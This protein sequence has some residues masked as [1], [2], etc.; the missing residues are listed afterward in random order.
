[1]R[2]PP[3]SERASATRSR[4]KRTVIVRPFS[5][6]LSGCGPLNA[7]MQRLGKNSELSRHPPDRDQIG[8][9]GKLEAA[10]AG[11]TPARPSRADTRAQAAARRAPPDALSDMDHSRVEPG[12]T[13]ALAVDRKSTRLN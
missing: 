2:Y 12:D 6:M 5:S 8:M 10:C 3:K 9:S 1:M 4:R 7:P 11:H 13:A